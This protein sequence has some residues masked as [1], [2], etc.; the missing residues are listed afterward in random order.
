MENGT[1]VLDTNVL[2]N[3]LD[4]IDTYEDIV[5]SSA[6]LEELDG[7]KK[8]DGEVGYRARNAIRKLNTATNIRFE[9]QDVY[10]GMPSSWNET[11]RDNIIVACAQ[12]NG[13]TLVSNDINV[14]VKARSLGIKTIT[15]SD[16]SKCEDRASELEVEMS[17]EELA[18]WY[19]TKDKQ[20]KWGLD[21]NQYILIKNQVIDENGAA[22]S[23]IVDIWV[24]TNSGF[25]TLQTKPIQSP[26]LG[27]LALYDTYQKTLVDSLQ[28]NKMTMVKGRAGTGK[29]LI[30]LSYALSAIEKGKYNKLIVFCNTVAT[31]NSAKLGYYPGSKDEKLL[32]SQI[33][34]MLS[35]K[36]G[37]KSEVDIL[38]K[39]EKLL[40]LP[41]SDIRGFDTTG[42]EAIVWVTEAQNLDIELMKLAIQRIGEDSQLIIDGDYNTQVDSS[43]Y[44]GRNNG[45]RRVSDVFRGEDFYGEVELK[46]IYRSRMAMI[47]DKM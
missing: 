23:K 41:I 6:V 14:V 32:D 2:L 22:E 10:N 34:N 17:D 12:H 44:E 36:L 16:E 4:V 47:A 15:L 45:M 28:N 11:K 42:M 29:S 18:E 37:D 35:S 43:A 9:C 26:Q 3:N 8:D 21:I 1:Y 33:G 31:K 19:K 5:L 24:Y 30:T 46:T 27:K 38:I 20:N 13:A 39:R 25:R 40:L 7:L